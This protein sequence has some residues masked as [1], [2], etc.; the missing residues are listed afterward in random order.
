[1]TDPQLWLSVLEIGSFFGLIALAY[2]LTLI[3]AGFFNFAIG[4]YAMAAAL[5]ASWLTLE[6][7]LPIALSLVLGLV[8]AVVASGLTELLVVR[9]VQKRSGRGELPALVAVT[10]VLFI[11]QQ[12]AGAIFGRPA[13]PGQ[14]LFSFGPWQIGS[15]YVSG[16]AVVL[17][18]A[19]A[20][21]FLA[22]SLWM[23]HSR[24][25]R[26]LRAVGD[27]RGAA[28]LLGLPV[29]RIRLIAFLLAGLIAGAAGLLYAPKTGV[30]FTSGL[31]WTLVGFLA[32]VIGGTGRTWAPLLGGFV[33]GAIQ[34][35]APFY[36]GSMGPTT[37]VLLIALL[38]FAFRPQGLFST[39][40]R[41]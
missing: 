20:L 6:I 22:V 29:G 14:V 5:G 39:R 21:I 7:G 13:L 23:R 37:M 26:L 31:S 28:A 10:A 27:N 32:L 15:A 9:Q 40:V 11:V 33:L 12:G 38:F 19:T 8:I 17:I 25:G 36:F 16:T 35:F 18:V 30:A 3:G 34:V 41:I 2:Q 4:P 1:M 24:T